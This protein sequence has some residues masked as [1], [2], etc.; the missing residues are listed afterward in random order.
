MSERDDTKPCPECGSNVQQSEMGG[1]TY[2][3]H[4]R[5]CSQWHAYFDGGNKP[6]TQKPKA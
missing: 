5:G 3:R 1:A 2:L 6:G 4:Y